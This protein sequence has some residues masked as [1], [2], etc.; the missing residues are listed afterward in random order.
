MKDPDKKKA[1]QLAKVELKLLLI[2]MTEWMDN[3][4]SGG[5]YAYDWA[6]KAAKILSVLYPGAK[7]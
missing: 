2:E 6:D 5:E 1:E 3:P 4:H 7:S